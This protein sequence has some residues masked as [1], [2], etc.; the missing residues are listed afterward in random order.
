MAGDE[1][2]P[3]K[4]GHCS[5]KNHDQIHGHKYKAPNES[6]SLKQRTGEDE[7]QAG[8]FKKWIEKKSIQESMAALSSTNSH[9]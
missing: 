9:H 6:K 5:D 4:Y 7:T 1:H 8:I 2:T 3:E